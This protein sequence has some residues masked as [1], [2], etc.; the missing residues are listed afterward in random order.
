MMNETNTQNP[1]N[2]N[3]KKPKFGGIATKIGAAAMAIAAIGGVHTAETDQPKQNEVQMQ[4][5]KTPQE[6]VVLP[7]TELTPRPV[8]QPKVV[9]VETPAVSEPHTGVAAEVE[10][11]TAP[12]SEDTSNDKKNDDKKPK[13][14]V[15]ND[16]VQPPELPAEP[17]PSEFT[18]TTTNEDGDTIII[19]EPP[20]EEQVILNEAPVDPNKQ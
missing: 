6:Q 7:G 4:I 2:K 20:T 19:N 13:V 15:G 14:V 3:I 11:N 8:E 9:E 17:A 1:E 5:D 16:M 18:D 10:S 12:Q